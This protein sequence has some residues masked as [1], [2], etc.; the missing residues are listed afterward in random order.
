MFYLQ[1]Q[2][3]LFELSSAN[4]Q[5]WLAIRVRDFYSVAYLL[6]YSLYKHFL[7][8][9]STHQP[10]APPG[11]KFSRR[12]FEASFFLIFSWKKKVCYLKRQFA[13]NGTPHFPC[14]IRKSNPTSSAENFTQHAKR[15][16][17]LKRNH[18]I[19]C[20]VGKRTFCFQ[21]GTAMLHV[22]PICW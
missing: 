21:T 10:S 19:M 14:K 6:Y 4:F 12:H 17:D 15:I 8:A 1:N 20:A 16:G 22:H 2:L 18:N 7:C 13:W 11:K 3:K 5:N 9:Q